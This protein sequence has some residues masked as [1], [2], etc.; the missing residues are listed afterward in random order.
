[1]QLRYILPVLGACLI[2]SGAVISVSEAAVKSE[3]RRL[4]IDDTFIQSMKGARRVVHPLRRY[5]GNPI[6]V[7]DKPWE[8]HPDFRFY[9]SVV[10]WANP[11]LRD[12]KTGK[13]RM[14]YTAYCDFDEQGRNTA[15]LLYAESDD[16]IHWIKPDLG[17]IEWKGSKRNNILLVGI[18]DDQS[19]MR[20][21]DTPNIIYQP[22]EP[23]PKN[24]Y[25]LLAAHYTAADVIEGVWLYRSADGLHWELVKADAI[26][27]AREFN[28]FFWDSKN[29]K[30]V[31]TVRLRRPV[32]PRHIAY[33]ESK[34]FINWTPAEMLIA[35]KDMN[36]RYNLPGDDAYGMC[37]F[38]YESHYV[39][40]FH[41]HHTDRRL[42]V[43][44]MSSIDARNW[45]FVGDGK[46]VLPNDLR[47][48]YGQGMMSTMSGPPIRVGDELWVYIGISPCAHSDPAIQNGPGQ[49]KRVIG[50]AKLRLDGFA[51]IQSVDEKAELTTKPFVLSGNK[52]FVN[53][54]VDPMGE[55]RAEFLDASGNVILGFSAED[56]RRMTSDSV[57]SE[58]K[59]RGK[60]IPVGKEVSLRF[61]F[62]NAGIY[63]F[64]CEGVR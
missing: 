20:Y 63:S 50:L 41:A 61:V 19:N 33:T 27:N 38:E 8:C 7:Q 4:L 6:I 55:V 54:R 42:E 59:W 53:A 57:R 49:Q 43:Q 52:L 26:P 28:S 23:E 10:M 25:K 40:F 62:R 18:S 17:I 58:I 36:T 15:L 9:P 37:S 64:W 39:S 47:G 13:F 1:M 30:Y 11:V 32:T 3:A 5:E 21:V 35:P 16:G 12:E 60:R 14:W 22:E 34:D 31:G 48:G 2:L 45:K 46:Y 56:C 51:S 29:R 44:L 24:R